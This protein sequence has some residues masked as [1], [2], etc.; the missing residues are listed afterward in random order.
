MNIIKFKNLQITPFDKNYRS[1]KTVLI[2]NLLD[3]DK[4]S[5]KVCWVSVAQSYVNG[6]KVGRPND[7][8]HFKQ[9]LLNWNHFLGRHLFELW[10]NDGP[11]CRWNFAS[12]FELHIRPGPN[13]ICRSFFGLHSHTIGDLETRNVA[14]GIEILHLPIPIGSASGH[15]VQQLWSCQHG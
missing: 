1:L 5:S 6:S 8:V 10:V 4:K 7:K 15:A 11:S 13:L 3:Y 9:L 14:L 2:F 12:H